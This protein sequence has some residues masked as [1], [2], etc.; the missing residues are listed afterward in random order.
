MKK[1]L[2]LK[3]YSQNT[4]KI[5]LLYVRLFSEYHQK[6]SAQ[7]GTGAVRNYL[8]HLITGKKCSSSYVNI[9]YSALKYLFTNILDKPWDEKKLPRMKRNKFLQAKINKNATVHTL[10]HCFATHL[11]EK[12]VDIFHIQQLLGHANPQTTA[13]YIHLTRKSVLNIKS[14]L[15]IMMDFDTDD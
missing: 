2:E 1:D 3:G 12:G 13:L 14:P 8:H 5:Y 10:R 6:P 11:L 4:I 15:D 7:L 9:N